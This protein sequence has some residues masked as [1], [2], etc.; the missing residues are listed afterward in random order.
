MLDGLL[1][2]AELLRGERE[3]LGIRRLQRVGGDRLHRRLELLAGGREL[4]ELVPLVA[5]RGLELGNLDVTRGC[6][7]GK[8]RDCEGPAGGGAEGSSED[9]CKDDDHWADER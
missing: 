7:R 3:E 1:L 6:A 9:E 2:L 8:A 5:E 4:G